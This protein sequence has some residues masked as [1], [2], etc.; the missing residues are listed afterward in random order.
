MGKTG[1]IERSTLLYITLYHYIQHVH[2]PGIDTRRV[3][4]IGIR[5]RLHYIADLLGNGMR[6]YSLYPE[7]PCS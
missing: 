7:T 3:V 5:T 1:Q 4:H 6:F 2:A